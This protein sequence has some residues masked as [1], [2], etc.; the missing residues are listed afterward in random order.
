MRPIVL[1]IA[2]SDPSS[3]AGIQ[4][5]LK[6]IEATGGYGATV[7]TAITVQNTRGVTRSSALAPDLVR[8]QLAAVWNDLEPAAV[9]SGMLASASI[10]CAV[11]ERIRTERPQHYV[12][13]PVMQSSDGFCL[14]PATGVEALRRE[15]IPLA[16]VLTPNVDDVRA[17]TGLDVRDVEEAERAG[18]RL[19]ALGCRAVLVKGGH[20]GGSKAID[21]LVRACGTQV[22]SSERLASPHTHGTGCVLSAAVAT[23][24]ALGKPL[25]DAIGAAKRIVT[26]AIRHGLPLGGGRGPTDPMHPRVPG[27]LHVIT[28]ETVQS[29]YS[30]LELAMLAAE[31]GAD[32]V[33]F[34]EKRVRT[35]RALVDEARSMAQ[36]VRERGARLLVNDRLDVAVAAEADG[37]HL[38]P[39]D[40]DPTSARRL[41]GQRGLIGATA[42]DLDRALQLTAA[43]IDYLGVGPVF[44]TSS[45]TA[46][47]A[48][49]GLTGLREIASA[50]VQPVIAIGNISPERVAAVLEAG[51][52]GVAVLSDVACH[53]DPAQRVREF[54]DALRRGATLAARKAE[55]ESS[56]VR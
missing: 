54:D 32:T 19:L 33:Q 16:T 3:G 4:A 21:V 22:F 35:T 2:G 42:N 36:Q 8:E 34:R 55:D 1:T 29:R 56:V 25:E 37:V 50:V 14:L 38:G 48:T 51:A 13:D 40:L 39:D 6:T 17:L 26:A 52:H 46:P 12:L 23:S 31:G 10:V 20:Y 9:K 44:G 7:I 24:L 11:A 53:A 41:L 15:L 28:D 5:D 18:R 47:A 49:L 27:R 43:P 30:H 45:K